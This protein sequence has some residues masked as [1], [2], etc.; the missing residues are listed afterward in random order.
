MIFRHSPSVW[1]MVLVAFYALGI[2]VSLSVFV[3]GASIISSAFAAA[4][5][6]LS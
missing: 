5:A 3:A 1:E 4:Q 2:L 6:A